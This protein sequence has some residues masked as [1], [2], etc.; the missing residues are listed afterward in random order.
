MMNLKRR[1]CLLLVGVAVGVALFIT[2][3]Y[4]DILSQGP[5]LEHAFQRDR[6]Q[7][8]TSTRNALSSDYKNTSFQC[9]PTRVQSCE[10]IH[11]ALVVAGYSTS[12]AVVP[13]LKSILFYR[14]NPLHF[15]FITDDKAR[16]VLEQ[17]MSTWQLPAV[18]YSLYR[19]E[20]IQH[21]ITWIPNLHYSGLYGLMK[22]VLPRLLPLSVTEV[23]VMDTDTTVVGDLAQLWGYLQKMRQTEKRKVFGLV[24]NQS[25]WYLGTIW[26]NHHPWPA[27]GRGF[28]TGVML[29]DLAEMRALNW[30]ELWEEVARE[31]LKVQHHTSLA[32]QDIVNAVIKRHPDIYYSLP[33]S[34]NVQL[35]EHTLSEQCYG[36]VE[37]YNIIHWNSPQKL[38]VSNK[39]AAYF[40]NMFYTFLQYNGN[41]LQRELL[42]CK[43]HRSNQDTSNTKTDVGGC[44]EFH[45]EA[46]IIHRVHPFYFGEQY[47]SNDTHD[48]TLVTQLSSD[49]IQILDSLIKKWEGP[50]SI[51]VYTTDYEA[52]QLSQFIHS[53]SL[54]F[55]RT[56]KN[57]G[58]HL[59]YKQGQFYPINKLRNIALQWVSTPYVFLSDI[60]FLPMFNLYDYLRK[61]VNV[62]QLDVSRRALVVPAFESLQYKMSFPK[63]KATLLKQFE[64]G[65]VQVFRHSL[66]KKGHAATNYNKWTKTTRPYKV[67]WM[68]DF[69]PYIVV[70]SNVTKFDQRFLGFGWNK[71]SHSM[72]LAAQGYDFI[73]LPEAFTIHMPHAPSLDIARYRTNK[74]YRQCV[75]LL[76]NQFIE[77]LV[78]KYGSQALKY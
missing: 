59:V 43:T 12:R 38:F 27:L 24:E 34:W 50:I 18:N 19:T 65:S 72:E 52:W 3:N 41:L 16:L 15:H 6:H 61:A 10:V 60:D 1:C 56:T 28:N 57:V 46:S 55:E 13:L 35:S 40:R 53:S 9:Q 25:N 75:Q 20:N 78:Q 22:L 62:L 7:R 8:L 49:R 63:D 47:A 14:H 5:Y 26:E 31:V 48:V 37:G 32:D 68:S 76:K 58:I 42:R 71:V 51:S 44:R 45:E 17:L 70:R 77:D 54:L 23:I 66:W 30:D 73:V 11:V 36:D 4:R 64:S 74:R 2:L 69:E 67:K 21:R 33:C 29:L 39:H